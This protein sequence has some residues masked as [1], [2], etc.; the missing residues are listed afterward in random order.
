[1][2]KRLEDPIAVT[3]SSLP[4]LE[5]YVEMLK[6]LWKSAWLTNMGDYHEQLKEQLKEYL[7]TPQLELFVNGHMALELAL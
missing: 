4:P 3:R 5:E 7:M 6:P 1:M 2:I